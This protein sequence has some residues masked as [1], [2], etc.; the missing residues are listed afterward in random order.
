L[1]SLTYVG[2]AVS[3]N[4]HGG[5]VESRGA[6][7]IGRSQ[8]SESAS[9]TRS[10]LASTAA[11]GRPRSASASS[12]LPRLIVQPAGLALGS[13]RAM[14]RPDLNRGRQYEAVTDP[15]IKH[16]AD[17]VPFVMV[18]LDPGGIG[19]SRQDG[20]ETGDRIIAA[21]EEHQDVVIAR[22]IGD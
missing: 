9:R 19:T 3:L 6:M 22:E 2:P 18:A 21:G 5:S 10:G 20:V 11:Y 12:G 14:A 15:S 4:A 17:A 16:G 13:I 1:R 8:L 7:R